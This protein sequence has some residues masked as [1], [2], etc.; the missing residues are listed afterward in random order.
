MGLAISEKIVI[1]H[2]GSLTLG[3][4]DGMT[5]ARFEIPLTQNRQA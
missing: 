1:D 4:N 2:D 5:E 3:V